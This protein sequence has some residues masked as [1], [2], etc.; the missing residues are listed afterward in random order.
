LVHTDH[1][2]TAEIIWA[3]LGWSCRT[4]HCARMEWHL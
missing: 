4:P 2:G 3:E 1:K